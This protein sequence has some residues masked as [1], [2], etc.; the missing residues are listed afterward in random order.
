MAEIG[1]A[2]SSE[3]FGPRELVGFARKAEEAG[4][5]FAL[6]SDHYHP[7]LESQGEAPFVWATIGGIAMVT[8]KLR[9]GTGVTC[10]LLRLH[11]AIVA[12]AAATAGAMM[13]GRFFL[14]V[15]TGEN[16]NEHILGEGW[17]SLE[18][19]QE[20]LVEA[21]E[22]IRTLWE[23]RTESHHGEFYT[24]DNACI[25][26]VPE[27]PPPIY[28]A[29]AGP[30][31]ARLAGQIGDGLISVAPKREVVEAWRSAADTDGPRI[32]QATVC[33]DETEEKAVEMA[34]QMWRQAALPG[35]LSQELALVRYF[36][37]ATKIVTR[38]QVAKQIVCGPDATRHIQEIEKFIEAGFDHVYIH[39][40]GP[41]QDG[42]FDFYR[43]EV[44]PHFQKSAAAT[45]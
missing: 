5:T 37:Q 6:I 28:V 3:E 23:G 4:F 10:P 25:Y 7:W 13:P 45:R 43:R 14:G 33:W 40:V 1:Y 21:V 17:P 15:G 27:A 22:L 9:L 32:G 24:V 34:W 30:E 35:E 36:E 38:E 41:R 19:R 44:L 18:V 8:E 16:L 39:Q 11:P 20:M 2:L 26:T 12:Q 42:F 31:S 29:A